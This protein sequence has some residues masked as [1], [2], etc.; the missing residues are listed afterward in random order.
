MEANEKVSSTDRG[1]EAELVIPYFDESGA[2]TS[3]ITYRD[4]ERKSESQEEGEGKTFEFL[5]ARV[6]D[7]IIMNSSKVFFSDDTAA[8]IFTEIMNMMKSDD[9][10]NITHY[11]FSFFLIIC[12]SSSLM[13]M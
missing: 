12:T 4:E 5:R 13:N 3:R 10:K 7:D 9:G 8:G 1:G 2:E 6:A 11:S